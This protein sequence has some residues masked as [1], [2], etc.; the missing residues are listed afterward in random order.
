MR[1]FDGIAMRAK[2]FA[3][4]GALTRDS[5]RNAARLQ[6]FLVSL[7]GMDLVR[8]LPLQPARIHQGRCRI[9][10]SFEYPRIALVVACGSRRQQGNPSTYSSMLLAQLAP[11]GV[12]L[13]RLAPGRWPR[14]YHRCSHGSSLSGCNLTIAQ[15]LMS[16]RCSV[17]H[18]AG[19]GLSY[20]CRGSSFREMPAF[21]MNR[22]P[23]SALRSS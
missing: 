6:R 20:D 9:G 4:L 10:G 15:S 3:G 19:A 12:G 22:I 18:T 23:L 2:R 16:Q 7:G 5:G 13:V 1:V 17:T 14:S 8:T 21:S 11:V